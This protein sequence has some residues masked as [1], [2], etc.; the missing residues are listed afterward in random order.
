MQRFVAA[1]DVYKRQPL[2]SFALPAA[3]L[4]HGLLKQHAQH[5]GR[6][7][8]HHAGHGVL[9]IAPGLGEDVY[10]RQSPTRR[11]P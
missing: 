10:K 6:H 8:R 9:G 5:H 2:R 4:L 1:R 7:V 11:Q 3:L